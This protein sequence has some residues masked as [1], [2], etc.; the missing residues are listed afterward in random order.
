MEQGRGLKDKWIGFEKKLI[1][2]PLEGDKG[3]YFIRSDRVFDICVPVP[4]ITE[5]T[6]SSQKYSLYSQYG[7]NM[8]RFDGH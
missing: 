3:I 6:I 7:V 5:H 1:C 2:H 8:N 4:N